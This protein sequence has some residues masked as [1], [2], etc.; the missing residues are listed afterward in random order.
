MRVLLAGLSVAAVATMACAQAA[1]GPHASV[2][3]S[4]AVATSGPV[5]VSGTRF[6]PNERVT[7][8]LV[9]GGQSLVNVV[10]TTAAGRLIARFVRGV[11]DCEGF[12]VSAVG[13][14]GSRVMFRQIP[15]P[16]GIVIQP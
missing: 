8:R 6:K 13:N 16:C 9:L 10:R 12:T 14:R 2:R 11:P 1:A 4:L 5:I 7:L 3:P 15:P